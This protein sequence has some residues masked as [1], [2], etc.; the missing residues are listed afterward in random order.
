MRF[1]AGFTMA[2]QENLCFAQSGEEEK[3]EGN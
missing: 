1:M 2:P 3:I